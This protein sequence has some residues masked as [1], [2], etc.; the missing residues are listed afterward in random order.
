M[1]RVKSTY[2]IMASGA[3]TFESLAS[4][5]QAGW[6]SASPGSLSFKTEGELKE[7]TVNLWSFYMSYPI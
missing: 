3:S 4:T 2:E 1:R 7:E 5:R 6:I